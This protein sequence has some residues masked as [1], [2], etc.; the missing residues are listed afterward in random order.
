MNKENFFFSLGF[1]VLVYILFNQLLENPFIVNILV[2]IIAFTIIYFILFLADKYG[3]K[4]NDMEEI[5]ND[6][7]P[8]YKS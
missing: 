4:L 2:F 6:I 7:L 5:N 3:D 8:H 1:S